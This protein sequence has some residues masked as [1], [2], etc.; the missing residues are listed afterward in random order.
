ME[1]TD[2]KTF[3]VHPGKAKNLCFVKEETDEGIHGWGESY[4]L[5]DRDIQVTADVDQLKLYLVGRN[6]MDIKHV[7][8]RSLTATS[9]CLSRP[10]WVSIW[11]RMP[12]QNIRTG[13]SLPGLTGSITRKGRS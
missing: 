11:M 2:V 12:W 13:N 4:T 10:D 5:S 8:L 1:V 7:M 6:P 3:L 9:K